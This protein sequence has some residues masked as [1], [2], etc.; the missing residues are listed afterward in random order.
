MYFPINASSTLTLSD[1][2]L[3]TCSAG[4]GGGICLE[5]NGTPTSLIFSPIHF[6]SLNNTATN[7]SEYGNALYVTTP[8]LT[9]ISPDMFPSFISSYSSLSEESKAKIGSDTPT[10]LADVF[11]IT[12]DFDKVNSEQIQ[13]IYLSSEGAD[14]VGCWI[15]RIGCRTIGYSTALL[16]YTLSSRVAFTMNESTYSETK[17]LPVNEKEVSVNGRSS[18]GGVDGCQMTLSIT[19]GIRT[20]ISITSEK[21]L[22]SNFFITVQTTLTES[23]SIV[24]ISNGG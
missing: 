4:G 17:M 22:L 1:I 19:D 24:W 21:C 13:P 16:L 8:S 9:H 2:T 23:Y 15:E 5:V 10:T 11:S 18:S 12:T 7:G 20:S 6:S 14:S 3:S